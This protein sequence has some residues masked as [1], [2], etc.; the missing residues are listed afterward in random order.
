MLSSNNVNIQFESAWALTNIASGTST[1][2]QFVVKSGAI[3]PFV[4]LLR[5]SSDEVRDQAVWALGNIAGDGHECRD[6]LLTCG[7]LP[8][9]MS[10]F[11]A[12]APV[13]LLRNATWALSN[14]CRGKPQ[15]NFDTVRIAI[16]LV[17]TLLSSQD[18]E[19]VVDACWTASYLSDGPNNKIQ[20]VIDGG[21]VPQLVNLMK[22][23]SPKVHI[24]AL[25]AVGNIVTGDESHTQFV[26]NC[27]PLPI[28]GSLLLSANK[29]VRKEAC[30][31]ISNITAGSESQIQSVIDSKLVSTLVGLMEKGDFDVR[32]EA[33]WA[34][35][36][37]ISG[38]TNG[39]IAFFVKEGCVKPM[40][41]LLSSTDAK[42]LTL[43]LGSIEAILRAG[44]TT[45]KHGDA[46]NKFADLV[47][48]SGAVDKIDELQQHENKEIY[49]KSVSILEKYFE[50]EAEEENHVPAQQNKITNYLF[51]TSTQRTQNNVFSF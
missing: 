12:N 45:N 22:H 19:I 20:A 43:V 18:L 31:A 3:P 10:V 47:E 2:T 41:E 9:L 39:Q 16:P 38:G 40:A 27:N 51:P 36:N 46:H 34:I 48:E 30:W 21:L 5:S 8:A 17:Y 44:E 37:A 4:E 15:P 32:K 13:S 49:Q 29:G 50:G 7:I 14:L 25:R 1:Q 33:C 42:V 24:P 6:Y 11:T 26:L 28:L 35:G 23:A